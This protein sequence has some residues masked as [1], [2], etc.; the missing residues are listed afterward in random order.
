MEMW[1]K[2][3]AR[4]TK[5]NW[6]GGVQVEEQPDAGKYKDRM[7]WNTHCLCPKSRSSLALQAKDFV[8]ANAVQ[9]YRLEMR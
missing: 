9:C 6:D 2:E 7:K 3:N 5:D 4:V 8:L 1:W